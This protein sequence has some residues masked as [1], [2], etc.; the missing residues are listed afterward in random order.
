MKRELTVL[1]LGL[2][3]DRRRWSMVSSAKKMTATDST[4][5]EASLTGG[6]GYRQLPHEGEWVG[7]FESAQQ[8]KR[9]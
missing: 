8:R 3:V 9:W 4:H 2:E 7:S 6:S 5:P 1:L